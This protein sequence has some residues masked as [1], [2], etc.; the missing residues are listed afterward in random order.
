MN[1]FSKQQRKVHISITKR[2]WLFSL[3]SNS[4]L[5]ILEKTLNFTKFI[6]WSNPV[7]LR[8]EIPNLG[9][10]SFAIPLKKTVK[11]KTKRFEYRYF[12]FVIP[13]FSWHFEG[14]LESSELFYLETPG[15]FISCQKKNK[16]RGSNAL[17]CMHGID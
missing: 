2:F 10:V 8:P 17:I 11:T 6:N 5:A 13:F 16:N 1:F 14:A 9:G 15:V 3:G 12:L 4:R 7:A